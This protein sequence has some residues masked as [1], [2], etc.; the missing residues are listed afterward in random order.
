VSEYI[1]RPAALDDVA[2]LVRLRRLMFESMGVTDIAALDVSDAACEAYFRQTI[3]AGEYRGWVVEARGR[4][5]A[6]AGYVIDQHPPGPGNPTGRIGYIMSLPFGVE[7]AHRRRGL[8][9]RIMTAILEH[10]R[11]E[12]VRVFALHATEVG[13]P[14]YESLGFAAS[15]EMRARE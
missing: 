10:L 15:N 9:R 14:L 7:P 12:G 3:P 11:A 6:S 5:V 13:R 4:V 2:D 8:A 1:L